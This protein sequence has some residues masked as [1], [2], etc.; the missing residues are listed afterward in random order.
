MTFDSIERCLLAQLADALIP[1]GNGFPSAS[2][3][4][5]AGAY[6]DQVLAVRADLG[7]RLKQI[8]RQAQ[9]RSPAEFVQALQANDPAGFGVLAEIVPGAYFLNPAVRAALQYDGQTVRAIDPRPDHLSEGLLRSVVDRGPI[10]R[11]TPGRERQP[12]V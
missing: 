6:L 10:Y 7:E 2:E 9:G 8:L 3:A 4:G 1:P 12:K 11:P 5:V